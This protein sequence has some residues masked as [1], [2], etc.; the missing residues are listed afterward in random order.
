MNILQCMSICFGNFS[1]IFILFCRIKGIYDYHRDSYSKEHSFY[2][3][4]L[5]SVALHE[6]SIYTRSE[7]S[8]ISKAI[9]EY[10]KSEKRHSLAESF[11]SLEHGAENR[12][13]NREKYGVLGNCSNSRDI[14][15]NFKFT[16]LSK[17]EELV[18]FNRK[19]KNS[20]LYTFTNLKD[21]MFSV[22][23][24]SL[25]KDYH[26]QLR[27]YKV[28]VNQ[29]EMYVEVKG[30][31]SEYGGYSS[32][33]L[34]EK[35]EY[36]LEIGR[37]EQFDMFPF[38]DNK[39]GRF[40]CLLSQD[41]RSLQEI[42]TYYKYKVTY[43]EDMFYVPKNQK[44]ALFEGTRRNGLENWND[45]DLNIKMRKEAKTN[46]KDWGYGHFDYQV[47]PYF[48]EAT[49]TCEVYARSASKQTEN[50]EASTVKLKCNENADINN[51]FRGQMMFK[52]FYEFR[53][54][55]RSTCDLYDIISK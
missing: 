20:F 52:N 11:N 48:N 44:E 9:R 14:G 23:M 22:I 29:P 24:L 32:K 15:T 28:Q 40:L 53:V 49:G 38:K 13:R 10:N 37:D 47:T 26:P 30:A 18:D 27:L 36:V 6:G 31:N 17:D 2:S 43:E 41:K 1:Q 42:L 16:S 4:S 35:G 25:D 21:G 34:L 45:N 33:Y 3:R 7:D 54:E 5:G 51:T 46:S 39:S 12:F 55:S 50:Y 19:L 8:A